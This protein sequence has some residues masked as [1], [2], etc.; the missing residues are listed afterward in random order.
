MDRDTMK[1]ISA[2]YTVYSLLCPS[3]RIAVSIDTFSEMFKTNLDM[4]DSGNQ[5]AV[6]SAGE[7]TSPLITEEEA[8][9]S[10]QKGI[11]TAEE[12]LNDKNKQEAFLKKLKEK[13]KSIPM[14]GSALSNVPT[15]FRLVS[16]YFKGEYENIPRKHLLIIISALT[17]LI[18]PIDLIPDFIPVAGLIDD[19][20]V[21]SACVKLTR[22]ELKK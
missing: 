20:A 22:P 18:S 16:S 17:Y 13:M 2:A 3:D 5:S 12:T 9:D 14:V 19:M 11:K 10:L 4:L 1:T 15:M 6:R 7:E 21:I 8:A